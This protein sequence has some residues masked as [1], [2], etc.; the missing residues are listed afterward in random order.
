MVVPLYRSR[1]PYTTSV[2]S[3]AAQT[4]LHRVDGLENPDEFEQVLSGVEGD[5]ISVVRQFRAGKFP[6]SEEERCALSFY[7]ALQAVRGPDTRRTME[8]LQAKTVRVEVGAGPLDG[9]H[10]ACGPGTAL[11][12]ASASPGIARDCRRDLW[13]SEIAWGPVRKLVSQQVA[14][15][16]G[17]GFDLVRHASSSHSPRHPTK[18][19]ASPRTR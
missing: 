11:V 15:Q 19:I 7:I 17:G 14:Q 1:K 12:A 3:V 16:P 5:A 6:P 4:H 9:S 18:Q 8:H 2:R 10:R 13:T